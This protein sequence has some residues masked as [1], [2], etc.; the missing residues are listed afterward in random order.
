M[1][2]RT[3]FIISLFL[4]IYIG[5]AAF[6]GWNGWVFWKLTLPLVPQWIYLSIYGLLSLGY[7]GAVLLHKVIPYVIYKHLKRAG[8]FGLAIF[9]YSI[10]L[11]PIADMV[12]ILLKAA[13]ILERSAILGVGGSV[14]IL[15]LL[16]LTIGLRN[17]WS[18]VIRQHRIQ[19][20]K[21]AGGRKSLRLAVA[22]DLHLG[23]MV[24]NKHISRL[25]KQLEWIKPD[26]ILLPGDVLD[27]SIEPF[28]REQMANELGK[29][30]APLGVWASLGNHEY[31]GGHIED[32]IERMKH[33]GITVLVDKAVNIEES[34]WIVGRKDYSANR[35]GK[36][37]R[38]ELSE[39]LADVSF[40][41]PIIV[42]DHQ[43]YQ[44]DIA[45]DADV[46]VMLSGHTHRGQ[47]APSHWIT[48]RLFELDWGYKLKDQLH[49]FVSSGFGLWGP[50]I[51]IGSRSEIL[52]IQIT[53]TQ[54]DKHDFK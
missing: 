37:S 22:S 6:V 19:I 30:R 42:M 13:G 14:L 11:L 47:M 25:I 29:L 34:F 32:Y 46:D 36:G 21:D 53:F 28:I 2:L 51:R 26:L 8:S 7:L 17:A 31:I 40:T 33:V 12:V 15:M 48:K 44:L 45:A 9:F 38:L 49:V 16:I 41:L 35:F 10:L 54:P 27:D 52:D 4:L 50:P 1:K 24:G 5:L 3:G 43:P 18:P 39:L 23:A 20:D